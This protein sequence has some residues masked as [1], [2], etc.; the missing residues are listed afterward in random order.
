MGRLVDH[1][2]HAGCVER[3]SDKVKLVNNLPSVMGLIGYQDLL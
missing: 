3:A 2:A 1:I